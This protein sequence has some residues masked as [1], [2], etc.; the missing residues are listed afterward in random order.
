M[1]PMNVAKINAYTIKHLSDGA[2][3]L[4]P[5][6]EGIYTDY[7]SLSR[8]DNETYICNECGMKEAMADY[9]LPSMTLVDGG[10]R[11]G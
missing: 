3:K 4:C 8:R 2:M 10:E 11:V 1:T 7:P 9:L 6:C 5:K